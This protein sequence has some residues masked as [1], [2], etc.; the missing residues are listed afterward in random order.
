MSIG[1]AEQA[2]GHGRAAAAGATGS[3]AQATA[4]EQIGA[5]V[6]AGIAGRGREQI[7]RIAA[8]GLVVLDRR[9]A[10]HAG[11]RILVRGRRGGGRAAEIGE[12]GDLDERRPVGEALAPGIG[13]GVDL[14]ASEPLADLGGG[15]RTDLLLVDDQVPDRVAAGPSGDGAAPPCSS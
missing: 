14:A 10:E 13:L 5:G 6:L 7:G 8:R 9:A 12:V 4:A 2:V 1:R 15:H 3:A 11:D